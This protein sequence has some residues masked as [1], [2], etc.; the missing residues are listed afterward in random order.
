MSIS[1]LNEY[2]YDIGYIEPNI[3]K[4]QFNI[5]ATRSYS[6]EF[7]QNI[8]MLELK[9]MIQKA[10][11]LRSRNFRLF[12]SGGEYTKF[13]DESFESLFPQQKIVLFTLELPKDEDFYDSELLLQ[14]NCP[15]SIH[16]DKF[17]L[18][19]CFTC[20]TSVCC[21]C[22]TNG[23]HKGHQIQDK[24]FYL[25]PS[26][27]L[28]DKLF[29]NRTQ[30]S[31]IFTNFRYIEDQTLSDLKVTIN[32]NIFDKLFSLLNDIKKKVN[33]IIEQYHY[34]N[35][36]SFERI[37]NSAKDLKLYYIKILDD[38]KEKMNIKDIINNDQIFLDFD[39]AYKKLDKIKTDKFKYNIL[40]Y[41]EYTQQIPSL[42]KNAI[43]DINKG[44]LFN[45]NLL[46]NDKKYDT[47]LNQ[48][49]IKTV[50]QLNTED[51]EQQIKAHIKPKYDD[52]TK[53]RLTINYLNDQNDYDNRRNTHLE[54]INVNEGKGRKTFGPNNISS[55]NLHINNEDNVIK[56]NNNYKN[57]F[58]F[59][60]N[61]NNANSQFIPLIK[62]DDN[63]NNIKQIVNITETTVKEKITGGIPSV[64]YTTGNI[65]SN[66]TIQP[67]KHKNINEINNIM[68]ILIIILLKKQGNKFH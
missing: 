4:A 58:L 48:I 15:C 24:C 39:K 68:T 67:S 25:L 61:D 37:R 6:L 41:N 40:L 31:S 55:F 53:K 8:S 47:I 59:N 27:Y 44:L 22:F 21:E 35:F 10:A 63:N 49:K 1:F 34:I 26:K 9:M 60:N 18:Y 3:V 42:I 45:L 57:L 16:E 2:P 5:S 64:V 46:A 29:E 62:N 23:F 28:V 66:I 51:I 7:D 11:H 20:N 17:L 65:K 56:Q 36:Q 14:M 13:N 43:D 33:N 50:K 12:S 32:K 52:F 19:Y 38:L 30:P 54:K